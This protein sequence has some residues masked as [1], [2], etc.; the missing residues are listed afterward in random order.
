MANSKYGMQ[1]FT[2][3]VNGVHYSFEA[4]TTDTKNGFCHTVRTYIDYS[5]FGTDTKVSYLNR[6]WESFQY[7]TCLHRAIDKCPKKDMQKL[8]DILIY[9]KREEEHEKAEN[10]VAKFEKTINKL[11]PENR[12]KLADSVGIIETEEQAQAI[13]KIASMMALMQ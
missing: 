4:W 6:T 3:D 8:T 5:R 10:F 11:T 13:M 9:R 2:A 7:E 1:S 12:Q